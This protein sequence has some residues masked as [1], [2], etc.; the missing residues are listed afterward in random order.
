[1][2]GPRPP[3]APAPP[4]PLPRGGGGGGALPCR[5][6]PRGGGGERRREGGARMPRAPRWLLSTWCVFQ[7]S[8]Y[9]LRSTSTK[10]HR[11][12]LHARLFGQQKS[13]AAKDPMS[14]CTQDSSGSTDPSQQKT[15]R[16]S[17][18]KTLREARSFRSKRTYECLTPRLFGPAHAAKILRGADITVFLR[19]ILEN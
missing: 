13:F 3:L 10:S 18:S 14:V 11:H 9:S 6:R 15:L 4:A 1:M 2:Q 12:S 16:V 17:H 8:N 5:W 7:N 19:K